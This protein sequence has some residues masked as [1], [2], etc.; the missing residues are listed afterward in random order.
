[1]I[2]SKFGKKRLAQRNY[3]F[4][5]TFTIVNFVLFAGMTTAIVFFIVWL[6]KKKKTPAEPPI[7]T[8]SPHVPVKQ[9]AV[10]KT[11][12]NYL[13]IVYP[14]ITENIWKSLSDKVAKNL[15]QSLCWYYTPLPLDVGT[16]SII[17]PYV[18]GHPNTKQI[19][20]IFSRR[21][22]IQDIY[23]NISTEAFLSDGQDQIQ[24]VSGVSEDSNFNVNAS[25]VGST[26]GWAG[27]MPNN[28]YYKPVLENTETSVDNWWPAYTD[29]NPQLLADNPEATCKNENGDD[30]PCQWCQ[31]GSICVKTNNK[32]FKNLCYSGIAG[33]A[34]SVFPQSPMG[35]LWKMGSKPCSYDQL[36][37]D[38]TNPE[39]TTKAPAINDACMNN[40]FSI[41]SKSDVNLATANENNRQSDKF[42]MVNII[43]PY[44]RKHGCP[45]FG[46]MECVAYVMEGLGKKLLDAPSCT[47][48]ISPTAVGSL[49]RVSWCIKNKRNKPILC[50]PSNIDKCK[51]SVMEW[52]K[53]NFTSDK[54]E[55]SE[56]FENY[57]RKRYWDNLDYHYNTKYD[58]ES[59]GGI[60]NLS[61][62]ERIN[63]VVKD[64]ENTSCPGC[65]YSSNT[66]TLTTPNPPTSPTTLDKKSYNA[67]DLAQD[68]ISK[69]C[70]QNQN[71]GSECTG[72]KIMF[73]WMNGY[74]KFLNM[75]LTGIYSNYIGF[76]LSCPN[77]PWNAVDITS[78]PFL[79]RSPMQIIEMG[80]GS[81]AKAQWSIF[82]ENKY[83][84]DYRKYLVGYSTTFQK[85][86]PIKSNLVSNNYSTIL[87]KNVPYRYDFEA[88]DE[89]WE[90]C[91]IIITGRMYYAKTWGD[92]ILPNKENASVWKNGNVDQTLLVNSMPNNWYKNSTGLPE[93]SKSP[94]GIGNS[95]GLLN[96]MEGINQYVKNNL[97]SPN[98]GK[99]DKLLCDVALHT[100]QCYYPPNLRIENP[101]YKKTLGLPKVNYG[102]TS[103]GGIMLW[104]AMYI[105]GDSGA[106]W[107]GYRN[108]A[109][110][111]QQI[112]GSSQCPGYPFGTYYFGAN[113]GSCVYGIT[114]ALGWN[115]SQ[116]TVMSTGGGGTKSCD[117]PNYDY[118]IVWIGGSGLKN[119]VCKNSIKIG[120]NYVDDIYGF[121]L[122][123]FSGGGN[124]DLIQHYIKYGYVQG[125]S[126]GLTKE[127]SDLICCIGS[128]SD[129]VFASKD[130]FAAFNSIFK[131]D[132][133]NERYYRDYKLYKQ[134]GFDA[135]R[136]PL[137][138]INVHQDV[139]K[140]N[141]PN[142][143]FYD[144][145]NGK[146]KPVK[147]EESYK[148]YVKCENEGNVASDWPFGITTSGASDCPYRDGRNG[149]RREAID[150][151]MTKLFINQLE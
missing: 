31:E 32:K 16:Q 65:C 123:D 53:T 28:K 118:E 129:V 89:D 50:D 131:S 49:S 55:K 7:P 148:E 103:Y 135:C 122:L 52:K 22:P 3:K 132:M 9:N 48:G 104:S 62:K 140:N 75:G 97:T 120:N 64:I 121:K 114:A 128:N 20:S 108:E 134:T 81:G 137:S 142:A 77:H 78:G 76:L 27:V 116:F 113:I 130:R 11:A 5:T 82:S 94:S 119:Q 10:T 59:E 24:I 73:Y 72:S 111:C 57:T 2:K 54:T 67:Y 23:Y 13:S 107:T 30:V 41:K 51:E 4:G 88:T 151:N 8:P 68:P 74:G 150:N 29:T 71:M 69:T 92:H 25:C 79:R 143:L 63:E 66:N 98:D 102:K 45:N 44:A 84:K 149:I 83:V 85:G 90:N 43:Q 6:A 124:N 101:C 80:V 87:K 21:A 61:E 146:C 136:M 18:N 145:P 15:Y 95:Q 36:D 144:K 133:F 86:S 56:Q 46:F 105:M 91:V 35:P 110:G 12:V 40:L 117:Y 26:S 17:L 126:V 112:S 19:K 38:G 33:A 96:P 47:T 125:T 93:F 139:W 42:Q 14:M 127:L 37:F 106:D 34:S 58:K 1:M 138:E 141:R 115:S 100:I 39:N 99:T 109:A 147:D 60:S 70:I